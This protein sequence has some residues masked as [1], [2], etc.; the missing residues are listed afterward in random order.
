MPINAVRT[1][2]VLYVTGTPF[3]RRSTGIVGDGSPSVRDLATWIF[4]LL[5]ERVSSGL[6]KLLHSIVAIAFVHP[7]SSFRPKARN[8]MLQ[9]RGLRDGPC[10]DATHRS[11]S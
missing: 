3:L 9:S 6:S 2:L 1:D 4:R 5:I 11:S 7:F 8:N 10:V